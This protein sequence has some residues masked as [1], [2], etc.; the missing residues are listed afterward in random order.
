MRKLKLQ[1]QVTLDGF[2]AAGPNDE[3]H[4][5]TWDLEGIRQYVNGLFDTSDTILIGRKL[6]VDYIP[7]WEDTFTRPDDPM[8]DFATRIVK[9]R[10]IVFTKTLEKSLWARTELAKGDLKEEVNKLKQQAGKDLIV[11]GGSS[12]VA[13]LIREGLIDEFHFFVNPIAIGKGHSAFAALEQW[14]PLKLVKSMTCGSGLLLLHYEKQ[15]QE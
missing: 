7:Y 14:Q 1:M 3:Q 13:S 2:N 10:K 6:A 11:Y 4:W 15:D 12:F 5:V 8:H 9:A